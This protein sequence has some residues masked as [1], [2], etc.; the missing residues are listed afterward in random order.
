MY[1]LV[2]QHFSTTMHMCACT[3]V[4]IRYQNYNT[5]VTTLSYSCYKVVTIL[6]L[7]EVDSMLFIAVI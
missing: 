1:V 4:L 7:S 6:I 3:C 5:V 2:S